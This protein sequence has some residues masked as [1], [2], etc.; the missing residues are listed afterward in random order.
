MQV[1]PVSRHPL[2][3]NLLDSPA[4]DLEQVVQRVAV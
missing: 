4:L 2:R 1:A 3:K